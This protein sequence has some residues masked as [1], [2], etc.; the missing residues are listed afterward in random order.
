V[1]FRWQV[2]PLFRRSVKFPFWNLVH[3]NTVSIP[4]NH[5]SLRVKMQA[6][7]DLIMKPVSDS[8]I[9][10]VLTVAGSDSG[11]GAGIQADLKACA[12]RRVY[13]STVITAVTAQNT[14]GVQVQFDFQFHN[15]H[16]DNSSVS[17]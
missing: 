1:S 11:G 3:T 12:A 16:N 8:K 15:N 9:P 7:A 14:V 2:P 5:L 17:F 6:Q 4:K 10:H 13:C